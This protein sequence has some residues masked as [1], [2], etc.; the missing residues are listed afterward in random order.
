MPGREYKL[1]KESALLGSVIHDNPYTEATEH[2]LAVERIVGLNEVG[3]MVVTFVNRAVS[4]M[5]IAIKPRVM[6]VTD[7]RPNCPCI[8]REQVFASDREAQGSRARLYDSLV[9]A[10]PAEYLEGIMPLQ[11]TWSAGT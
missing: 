7:S 3:R 4:E 10:T 9:K 11:V 6:S 5:A 2:P 8:N 1:L